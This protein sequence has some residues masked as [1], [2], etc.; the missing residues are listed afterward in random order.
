MAESQCHLDIHLL[1]AGEE[2][3]Y[4]VPHFPV[5][6]A[7]LRMIKFTVTGDF[8]VYNGF[9]RDC[10]SLR[11]LTLPTLIVVEEET[12]D[13]LLVGKEHFAHIVDTSLLTLYDNNVFVI[14]NWE[15][16]RNIYETTLADPFSYS[17][18]GENDEEDNESPTSSSSENEQI[19]DENTHSVVFK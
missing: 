14:W 15:M 1:E 19:P 18:F 17:I 7:E 10:S 3:K 16:G 11:Q 9:I 5:F 13:Y 2:Y 8:T 6:N 4:I 12:N